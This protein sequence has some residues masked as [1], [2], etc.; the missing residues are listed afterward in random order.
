M[1][2]QRPIYI[3]FA[4]YYSL[5]PFP[6]HFAL[7]AYISLRL[8][9]SGFGLKEEKLFFMGGA[10]ANALAC[11]KGTPFPRLSTKIRTGSFI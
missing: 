9:T 8:I 6:V 2:P 4:Q 11:P 5:N 7:T 1:E 10:R 3:R